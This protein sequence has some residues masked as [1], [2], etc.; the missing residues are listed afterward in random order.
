MYN[1]HRRARKCRH[2]KCPADAHAQGYCKA[3]H[4]ERQAQ[5]H[6]PAEAVELLERGTTLDNQPLH[7]SRMRNELARLQ[8]WWDRACEG[9]VFGRDLQ[10]MPVE[11]ARAAVT[12]C[13][14][15]AQSMLLADRGQVPVKVLEKT[16]AEVWG[17][18]QNLQRGLYSDGHTRRRPLL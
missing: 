3:H 2:V 18:L 7:S 10:T 14:R 6:D 5:A 12:W 1:L 15:L 4:Q 17:R 8:T 11:E 9:A 16:R 13:L